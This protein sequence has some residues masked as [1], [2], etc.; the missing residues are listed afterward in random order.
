MDERFLRRHYRPLR[1]VYGG[2]STGANRA[3]ELLQPRSAPSVSDELARIGQLHR[4]PPSSGIR[5]HQPDGAMAQENCLPPDG[6]RQHAAGD[7]LRFPRRNARRARWRRPRRRDRR[8][9]L[10]HGRASRSHGQRGPVA[11]A[12]FRMV[13]G[14]YFL[15]SGDVFLL[16]DA[17]VKKKPPARRD[18]KNVCPLAASSITLDLFRAISLAT[19]PSFSS[20]AFLQLLLELR[21]D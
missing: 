17:N 5:C 18:G 7:S 12:V 11:A 9:L 2:G 21:P 19:S 6:S 4:W 14:H 13:T 20:F 8:Y 3:A 16:Q 15:F 1:A 10:G